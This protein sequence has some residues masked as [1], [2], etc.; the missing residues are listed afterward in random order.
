MY[1]EFCECK[2]MYKRAGIRDGANGDT[3]LNM[4]STSVLTFNKRNITGASLT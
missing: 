1:I 2:L 4:L 3:T